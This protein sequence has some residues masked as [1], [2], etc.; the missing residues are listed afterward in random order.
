[1]NGETKMRVYGEWKISEFFYCLFWVI[2]I[3][4]KGT[5]LYEGL[6][7]YNICLVLALCCLVVKLLLTSYR[8]ADLLWAV[9]AGALSIWIY[10]HSRDQSALLLA[11]MA[12]GIKDV[13]LSRVLKIGLVMWS[14][15]FV[16]SVFRTFSGGY[17]G[18]ILVHEK[19]GLGPIIRWSLGFTHPNVLHIT[20]VVIAAML[21]YCWNLKPGRKQ[22]KLSLLLMAG[23]CYV[24]FYSISSTGFLLMTLLLFFNLYLTNRK[25]VNRIE[26]LLLQLVLPFCIFFSLVLP[27]VVR[28]EGWF[29]TLINKVLN[30]RYLATRIYLTE[31]GLSLFGEKLP[32]LYNF[33]VDCSYTEAI[34]SYGLVAFVGIMAGYMLTIHDK[35]RNGRWQELAILLA[36]LAAGVSEPFLFNASFKNIII[37]FVGDYLYASV[38]AA[39]DRRNAFWCREI[40]MASGIDWS[41][42]LE[43]NDM[44]KVKTLLAGRWKKYRLLMYGIGILGAAGCVAAA[45]FLAVRPD[46]IFIGAGS[47]DCGKQEERYLDMQDLP[48]DF[49][50]EI[51]E[52]PGPDGAMYEFSGTITMIEYIRKIVSAGVWGMLG[53][54]ALEVLLLFLHA[55]YRS[56][57]RLEVRCRI[58]GGKR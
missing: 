16:F 15:C 30:T 57:N 36:L 44:K 34:L 26:K 22:W 8:I 19:F 21:L 23:N 37:L 52:Y 31:M 1:M 46:S 3:W 28:E 11:A 4:A 18:P 41:I 17:T 50:S 35:I 48:D 54:V 12:I 13:K 32:H 14:A 47:T 40:R 29:F 38:S 10:L 20:Y 43:W 6:R 39:E 9:P 55:W 27:V 58:T 5:G 49:N 56:G 25:K 24:F 7:E 33:A 51:Y 45:L 2:M 42:R 53:T